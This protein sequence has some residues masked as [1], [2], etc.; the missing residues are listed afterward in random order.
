MANWPAG[1][2]AV[3]RFV[4]VLGGASRGRLGAPQLAV[5]QTSKHAHLPAFWASASPPM[6]RVV[7]ARR[8]SGTRRPDSV[9][10]V[11]FRHCAAAFCAYAPSTPVNPVSACARV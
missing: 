7:L 5:G 3:V 1:R 6:I 9:V 11:L 10:A 8:P 4:G 2:W